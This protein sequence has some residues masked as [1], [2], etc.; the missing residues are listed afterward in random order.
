MKNAIAR[1]YQLTDIEWTPVA[2]MPG[3]DKINGE[4]TVITYEA[5]VTYKG[6]PYSGTT[7]TIWA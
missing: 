7:A 1:A 5:G 4:F 3:V 2:S 6:I